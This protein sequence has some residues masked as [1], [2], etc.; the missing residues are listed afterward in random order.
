MLGG[1]VCV[2]HNKAA[3]KGVALPSIL[4]PNH[5]ARPSCLHG[6]AS[7]CVCVCEVQT[8]P[9]LLPQL[10]EDLGF[11]TLKSECILFLY[12]QRAE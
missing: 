5:P 6:N 3:H 9:T 1:A 10:R 8:V 11:I 2:S 7:V 4:P 12:P